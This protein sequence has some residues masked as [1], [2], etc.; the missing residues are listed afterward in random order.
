VP[1]HV[2]LPT[3][4]DACSPVILEALAAGK[5]VITT[6]YNGAAESLGDNKYGQVLNRCDDAEELAQAMLQLCN[7]DY[8]E[9]ISALIEQNR[10]FEQVS[11]MRHA[12][13]LIELYRELKSNSKS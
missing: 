8:R 13:E 12:Q 2:P 10:L 3:D 5:P 7:K 9:K 1:V 6:R 11:M 4:N